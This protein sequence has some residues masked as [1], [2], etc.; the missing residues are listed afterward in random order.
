MPPGYSFVLLAG[1]AIRCFQISLHG[2]LERLGRSHS[3]RIHWNSSDVAEEN[4]SSGHA[5]SRW[6]FT[7]SGLS[8]CRADFADAL[9]G[10]G[11]RL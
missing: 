10:W 7:D 2:C 6:S 4:L 3:P 8:F 1:L 9:A 5:R 11:G